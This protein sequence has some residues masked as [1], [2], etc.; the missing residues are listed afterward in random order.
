MY[1]SFKVRNFR[2][3]KDLDIPHLKRINLIAGKNN[4]GKTA[5]LEALFIHCGAYNPELTARINAIRGIEAVKIELGKWVETPWDSLFYNFDTSD[6]IELI[7]EDTIGHRSLKLRVIRQPSE[8]AKM[9][10]FINHSSDESK[11]VLTS[12]ESDESKGVLSSSEKGVLSSSEVA[13]VLEL[14]CGEDKQERSFYMIIDKKAIRIEPVPPSPPFPGFFQPARMRIPLKQQAERFGKLEVYGK[15]DILLEILKIIEPRLKRLATVVVAGEPILHG[16]IGIGR[17]IPLPVMG[18]GMVRLA[19][20]VLHIGNAPKGVV[21]IDEIENG[22]HHSIMPKIWKAIGE[23]ARNFDTQVFATTHSL[24]C[25]VAA[26]KAFEESD[27]YDFQLY[28]LERINDTINVI[29]YDQ[30]D[31]AT[32]IEE[33][34][35]VR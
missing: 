18:E 29:S 6:N 5:L 22:I 26:H 13:Q 1:K 32:A 28:R 14:R 31:L 24:E 10:Q 25:I 33:G 16:D 17:L 34:F 11:G 9:R 30:E 8:L 23:A 20:L 2:C 12:S 21:L 35:E 19:D 27:V 7:G 3:F 4:V 15:Q